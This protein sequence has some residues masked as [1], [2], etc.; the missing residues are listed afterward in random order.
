MCKYILTLFLSGFAILLSAQTLKV[1]DAESEA[2]LEMVTISGVKSQTHITTNAAGNSNLTP[3]LQNETVIINILGYKTQ[4]LS[5]EQLEDA[6][7]IVKLVPTAVNLDEVVISATRWRQNSGNQPAK[8]ATVSTREIQL[9][10]PQTAADLLNVSGKVFLQ[11]SQQG[12]GSPMIR[13]FATNRLLYTI[14]GVRMNTAIF[15]SGNLQS[16]IS[17]DP[18]A[19]EHTEIFFGPG[20]VIY[21]SDAIGGVMSFQTLTPQFSTTDKTFVSGNA[22]MRYATANKENTGHF[23]AN[24]GGKKWAAVTSISANKYD[25]L[26]MGTYGS[27]DYLMPYYVDRINNTDVVFENKDPQLQI[28]SDYSQINMMQ[29]LRW[30]PNASWDL[31]Y[32][33]HYSETSGYSRYDRHTRIKNDAPRYAQ[34]D[35]GPQIWAMNNLSITHSESNSFYDQFTL[36]VAQQYFEESRIDRSLHDTLQNNTIE[37]VDAYSIN[38]DFVK[39]WS[40]IHEF[41]YGLEYILNDVESAAFTRDIFT[42]EQNTSG[43]RYPQSKWASYAI[44]ATN[45]FQLTENLM[46][47]TGLRYNHFTLDSEFDTDHYNLAFSEAHVNKDALTGNVGATYRPNNNWIIKGNLSSGFRAPNVD[48]MG[49]MFDSEESSVTVPNPDLEAE[50]AYNADLGIAHV[51]NEWLK[52]DVAGFYT[53]LQNALVRRNFTINGLDSIMYNGEMSQ[54]QAIQNAAVATV[55][56]VQAGLEMNLPAGF[57][58]TSDFNFQKGEEELDDGTK[59]PSR[60]ASPWFG[61]TRLIYRAQNLQMQLYTQYSGEV[62]YKDLAVEEQGK[63]YLY[64]KDA[65]GNPYAPAWYTLNIK[66]LY[67]VNDNFQITAGLENITDRRYRPYSSGIAAAGRNFILSVRATF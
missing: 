57:G 34:W 36:R 39:K 1:I 13:G 35:Y 47:Q 17:L 44:Y 14:D 26:R 32:G 18:F 9:Q 20:S 67:R 23:H 49:K 65:N 29:K 51:F 24:V 41:F 50:Y 11:K 2:P 33:F 38:T 30:Q 5:Y 37:K 19:I 43:P 59:S 62:K 3:F 56:G 55:Y 27:D 22:V 21:G 8:I 28:P 15:R 58:L 12:G 16:V 54:V 66:A 7:F 31:Q 60:H 46:L 25:H 48:D 52:I 10:N 53:V 64:A 42:N 4:K 61:I 6:K 40:N 45:H 63:P